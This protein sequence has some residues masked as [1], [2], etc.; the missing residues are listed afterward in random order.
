MLKPIPYSDTRKNAEKMKEAF[1]RWCHNRDLH[2]AA[3][4]IDQDWERMV[5]FYRFPQAHWKHLRTTN[6][7]ESPFAMLRLRTNAAK[8]FKKVANATAVIWKML[9]IAESRFRRI[10]APELIPQVCDGT[11][12]KDGLPK[13]SDQEAAA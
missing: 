9:M 8:R 11:R 2:K 10:A 12:F 5:T 4:L 13:P 1:Q 6:V 7:V 3:Q